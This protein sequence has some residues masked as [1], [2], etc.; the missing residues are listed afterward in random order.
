MRS[1]KVRGTEFGNGIPKIC[2]PIV[3]KTDEEILQQAEVAVRANPDCVELRIDWYDNV[4]DANKVTQLLSKLRKIIGDIVLLFTFRSVNEGGE[5]SISIEQYRGLY[6]EACKSRYIDLLDVEAFMQEGLLADLVEVAHRYN[7]YV[8]GSN[9]DFN[10]TPSEEELLYRLQRIDALGADIP[11]LAV[12]PGGKRDVLCL[13]SATLSYHENG[14][15]K[16]II[17]MS[18]GAMGGIS[19]LAGEGIGSVLTFA[20]VG[21][22]SAPGQIPIE[23]VRQLLNLLHES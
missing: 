9:H 8:V 2:V 6:E 4:Y 3:G 5:K 23:Q 16:P 19:R 7:V 18:M 1:I 17:T 10:G 14:G 11:K 13:M 22:A 15:E 21:R 20:T 12:M